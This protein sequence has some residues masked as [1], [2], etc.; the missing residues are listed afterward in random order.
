MCELDINMHPLFTLEEQIKLFDAS[1][2]PSQVEQWQRAILDT[3]WSTA[4][5]QGRAAGANMA[6]V[7]TPT[8]RGW[9]QCHTAGRA[10]DHHLGALG[11]GRDQHHRGC[12]QLRGCFR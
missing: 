11:S 8:S 4:M 9:P 3:L 1:K 12:R 6:G 10:D 5:L 7:R 2:G